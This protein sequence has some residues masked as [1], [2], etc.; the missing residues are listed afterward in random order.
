MRFAVIV[1]MPLLC[2][3]QEGKLTFKETVQRAAERYPSIQVTR[4]QVAEAAASVALARNAFL[5]RLDGVAQV[6]RATANNVFGL[7][8][9]TPVI[10]PISGPQI[11]G[12]QTRNVF[13]S[14][15]GLLL[16]DYRSKKIGRAHV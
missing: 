3:A 8:F 16:I 13:G 15:V 7:M 14:S 9:P 12:D 1:A 5:P 10:P 11:D 4:T 6:N 2:L